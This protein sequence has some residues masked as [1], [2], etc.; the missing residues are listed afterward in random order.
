MCKVCTEAVHSVALWTR[1]TLGLDMCK[2]CTEAVHSVALWTRVTLGLGMYKVCTEAVHSVALWT[3]VTLGLDM[4]KVCTEAVHSV[5]LW[6]R[7]TLQVW[8]CVHY[9]PNH[10]KRRKVHENIRPNINAPPKTRTPGGKILIFFMFTPKIG[11]E[12]RPFL[13]EHMFQDGLVQPPTRGKGLF[14]N[15]PAGMTISASHQAGGWDLCQEATWC[16][17]TSCNR[18]RW[19]P[20]RGLTYPTLGK[21]KSSWKCHFWGIC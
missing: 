15:P 7:V 4:C 13:T 14:D 9:V 11:E 21:G 3:Q 18:K 12:I 8:T 10:W 2:V 1:V 17:N 5:A 20:S 16:R 6:T 19:I